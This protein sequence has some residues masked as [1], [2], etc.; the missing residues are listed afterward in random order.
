MRSRNRESNWRNYVAKTTY[1][2][3]IALILSQT[4]CQEGR[5]LGEDGGV[6]LNRP[7]EAAVP[8]QEAFEALEQFAQKDAA[9]YEARSVVAVAG[10]YLGDILRHTDPKRALDVYDHSLARI[11]EVPNDVSARRTE[12]LLL[13]G[14]SYALRWIH[15][16][17]EA[18]D[19][20]D[21]AIGF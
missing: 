9:Y 17:K 4:R 18:K 11:R 14:S 20:I 12:A 10:H 7:L 6:N 2:V 5:I 13:A 1:P 16:E 3:Y 21:A 8:L 19:R 15:R